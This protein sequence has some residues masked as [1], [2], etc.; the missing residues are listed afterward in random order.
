METTYMPKHSLADAITNKKQNLL[1]LIELI[2]SEIIIEIPF[3]YL[4]DNNIYGTRLIFGNNKI[5][6]LLTKEQ[7]SFVKTLCYDDNNKNL[8]EIEKHIPNYIVCFE[9]E[10][11][12]NR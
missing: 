2:D 11:K 7:T 10:H 5:Y 3:Q 9:L 8:S 4:F 1:D 12:G 6:T